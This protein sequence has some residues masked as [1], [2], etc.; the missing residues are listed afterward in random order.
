M[1][2]INFKMILAALAIAFLASCSSVEESQVLEG[3]RPNI[4]FILADDMGWNETGFNGGKKE[5]TP[6]I[7]RLRDSGLNL[8]QF[9]VHAVCAPSRA[10]FLT[11][12]YAFRTWSDWRS[13]DFGKP[14]Y[15]AKLGM[16][17]VKNEEGDDTRRIHAL[18]TEERTVAEALKE[19]G[20]FTAITGKWHCGEWLPE[21]LPMGQGFMHQY[22]HYAWGIDYNNYTIPHNA[23]A[24][25]AVYD[26]HRNQQPVNE[27]G[28]TTDLIAN[29]VVNLISNHKKDNGDK[30]FFYY[31]P[32]NAVHGPLEE[33]PRYTDKYEKRYA[34]LKCL[35]DAVG[36]IVGAI[37]QHGY[38]DNT[39]VIFCNDNGG[40]RDSMNAPYRGTK[41]TNYEGGVR[42]PCVLR[43]PGKLKP[44]STSDE[45]MHVTDFYNTF[46]KLGGGSLKQKFK[47]DGMDMSDVIFAGAKSQRDEIIFEVSGSVRFPAIRKGDYKLVGKE[48]YNIVKDPSEKN[49]ISKSHPDIVNSLTNRVTAV[50]KERPPMPDMN[51]L[52]TPAQPWVYGQE[53]NANTPEWLKE[54][55]VKVRKTQ[56]QS[57]APGKTPWPQ[58]P[59]DGKIIYTGDGR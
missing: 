3:S 13:E 53:E 34:A 9:Y 17:L 6:N 46:I 41:N 16:K 10:A 14:T 56:P 12:R 31:V 29:E 28:Y 47:L 20:Y 55:M 4:V 5:Y 37:D 36:R 57:W 58:A 22:G 15:L 26:W 45:M 27:Q 40:L 42:V 2:K 50:G 21:H 49:D 19:E 7:D 18:A 43:W 25:F 59:K 39:L 44:G 35:D 52:M 32:F 11:G 54:I 24:K 38:K 23:P 1:C 48:L 8:T 33:I 51:I 30:P